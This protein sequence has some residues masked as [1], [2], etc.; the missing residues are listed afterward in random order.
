MNEEERPYIFLGHFSNI[1]PLW[2]ILINGI[3]WLSFKEKSRKVV[4]QAHQAIFFHAI[5]LAAILVGGIAQLLIKLIS[6]VNAPVGH[7]F[8]FVNF[9][10]I[11]II[12]L[13]YIVTCL[14]AMFRT[15]QGA[16]FEY[17]FVGAKLRE[18]T[19]IEVSPLEQDE[20]KDSE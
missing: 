18:E 12:F 6:V 5:F 16:E 11:F 3:L 8:S 1:L 2:G 20:D 7:L 15:L 17:P 10:I 19:Q 4:F 13:A 14:Y 9:V